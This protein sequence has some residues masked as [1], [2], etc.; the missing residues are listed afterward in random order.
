MMETNHETLGLRYGYISH[1][2]IAHSCETYVLDICSRI[3]NSSAVSPLSREALATIEVA[4]MQ[5]HASVAADKIR[6]PAT[7]VP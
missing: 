4:I 7:M 2:Y 1:G 3:C 6:K 5:L